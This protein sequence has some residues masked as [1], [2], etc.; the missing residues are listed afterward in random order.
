MQ[1]AGMEKRCRTGSKQSMLLSQSIKSSHPT[2]CLEQLKV[3]TQPKALHLRAAR[4]C[5]SACEVQAL[6]CPPLHL[7]AA[8]G[9][10][11]VRAQVG[12]QV[13]LLKN[14]DLEGDVNG[15]QLVNG[16]RG[17]VTEMVPKATVLR[18]LEQERRGLQ[19]AAPDRGGLLGGSLAGAAVRMC[20]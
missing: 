8:S 9:L 7:S 4:P 13:M 11:W 18:R 16:S 10:A 14:V 6:L 17:V 2:F 20:V 3:L 12:A 15:R 5:P 19:A 1:V